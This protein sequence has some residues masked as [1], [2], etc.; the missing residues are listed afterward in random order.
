MVSVHNL[1]VQT[2]DQVSLAV[3]AKLNN[4]KFRY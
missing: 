2:I 1:V 4:E 3:N